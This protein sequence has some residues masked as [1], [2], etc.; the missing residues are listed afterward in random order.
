MTD[1]KDLPQPQPPEDQQGKMDRITRAARE[2]VIARSRGI[3]DV[4]WRRV[5][6]RGIDQI[7]PDRVANMSSSDR[8]L[9]RDYKPYILKEMNQPL[10]S[11]QALQVAFVT[12]ILDRERK[13]VEEEI[14]AGNRGRFPEDVQEVY[15]KEWAPVQET[16]M[17]QVLDDL[18]DFERG[19]ALDLANEV[20]RVINYRVPAFFRA[21]NSLLFYSAFKAGEI[22]SF[23]MTVQDATDK[24]A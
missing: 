3:F 1:N 16:F 12:V 20:R 2:A 15:E 5:K 4:I 6:E 21:E 23:H 9:L 18:P 13:F 17:M 8:L 24:A 19:R 14:N 22:P 11:S 7:F 10:D